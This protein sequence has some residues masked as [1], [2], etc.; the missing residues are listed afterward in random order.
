MVEAV[1]TDCGDPGDAGES[2]AV[3]SGLSGTLKAG[4]GELASR[5]TRAGTAVA[6]APAAGSGAHAAPCSTCFKVLFGVSWRKQDV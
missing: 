3:P 4:S 5:R 6:I 2:G 1:V